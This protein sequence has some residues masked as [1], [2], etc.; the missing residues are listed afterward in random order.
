MR[1]PNPEDSRSGGSLN[2]HVAACVRIAF[3]E[4]DSG[5]CLN[6]ASTLGEFGVLTFG[7]GYQLAQ[8]VAAYAAT[9]SASVLCL[10]SR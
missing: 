6:L 1:F 5:Y 10:R 3:S 2:Q 7:Q 4:P 9:G 8:E